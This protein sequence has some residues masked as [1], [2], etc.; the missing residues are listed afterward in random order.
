LNTTSGSN[1]IYANQAGANP[2][3]L[4]GAIT[5]IA[6]AT[7]GALILGGSNTLDNII[8]VAIPVETTPSTGGVTKLGSGTWVLNAANTYLGATTIQGGTLK[9]RATGTASDVIKETATNTVV[10][11]SQAVTGAAG[12]VLEFRGVA[13]GATTE[14]LGALTPTA[15]ASTVRLLGQGGFA[16]SLVFNNATAALG[17]TAAA[18][19]LNFDTAGANGGTI[20]FT[21]VAPA[22]ATATTLPGTANFQGHLYLNGSNFA[23]IVAGVVTAPTYG[24]A[25]N[26]RDA[27]AALVAATH[28][29]LTAATAM[30]AG[31]TISSLLTN[32]QTLTMSGN[33][34]VSTGGILQSGGTA[35][36]LSNSTT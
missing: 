6:A 21:G 16:A 13:T 1:S 3:I 32:S 14:T 12:G 31:T 24:G 4:N 36:I 7:T 9:L 15:G 35:S 20:S 25:G 5:K 2:V 8:N 19:S 26:F 10:F 29:R 30:A 18:T 28:N 23:D 33:L 34:V 17:A 22:A 11:S 27:G